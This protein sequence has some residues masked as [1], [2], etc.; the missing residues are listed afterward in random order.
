MSLKFGPL[1][2]IASRRPFSFV[3]CPPNFSRSHVNIC[4]VSGA[5]SDVCSRTADDPL[6]VIAAGIVVAQQPAPLSPWAYGFDTPPGA[7]AA[8]PAA[9]AGGGQRG[10]APAPDPTVHKLPGSEGAFTAAQ[11]RD[12]F[13]P[14]DWYPGD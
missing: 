13:G 12:G 14:A 8:A 11:I 5:R 1:Y 10:Q 3:R 2:L 9:P 7:P 6:L 4:S